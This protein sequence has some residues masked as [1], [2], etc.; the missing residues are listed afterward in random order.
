MEGYQPE[1]RRVR[2][3]VIGSMRYE[4]EVRQ[5]AVSYLVQDLSGLGVTV[6]VL[7]ARLQSTQDLERPFGEI[8]IYQQILQRDDQ[9]VPTEWG[10]EP[11]QSRGGQENHMIRAL[12]RQPEGGHVVDRLMPQAIKLL[13]AGADLGYGLLPLD[14]RLGMLGPFAVD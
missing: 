12:D 8:R 6:V 11:R 14:Q 1:R 5:L 4:L 13:V 9:A 3:A 10:D 7:L 2:G